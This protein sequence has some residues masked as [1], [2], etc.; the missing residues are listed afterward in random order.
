MRINQLSKDFKL[1]TVDVKV[2][3]DIIEL[4]SGTR[5]KLAN[6]MLA[7][8]F[9]GDLT[10]SHYLCLGYIIGEREAAKKQHTFIKTLLVNGQN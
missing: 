1:S 7:K 6:K 3:V 10:Y 5:V 2:I 9:A 8:V 4:H